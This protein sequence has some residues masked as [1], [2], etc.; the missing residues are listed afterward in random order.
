MNL[1]NSKLQRYAVLR[2]ENLGKLA[3]KIVSWVIKNICDGVYITFIKC[4]I[5]M[6]VIHFK[7]LTMCMLNEMLK[8]NKI[9]LSLKIN[10]ANDNTFDF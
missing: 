2:K 7:M 1:Y 10:A 3:R 8:G 5:Y 6:Y 4:D 9:V